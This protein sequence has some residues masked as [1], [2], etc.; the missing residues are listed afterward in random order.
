MNVTP[1]CDELI[2]VFEEDI[3]KGW[4]TLSSRKHDVSMADAI[5]QGY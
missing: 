4:L 2:D 5:D 3:Q 1:M